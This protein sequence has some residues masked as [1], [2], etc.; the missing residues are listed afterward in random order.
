MAFKFYDYDN[1]NNIGSVDILNL[2]KYFN[3]D[4]VDKIEK[5]HD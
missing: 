2:L 1:N 4:L 5:K 3:V